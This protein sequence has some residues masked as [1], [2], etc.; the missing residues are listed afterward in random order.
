MVRNALIAAGNSGDLKLMAPIVALLD[1]REP[2]VRSAAIWSLAQVDQDR[3][4]HER[5]DRLP[6]ER[7]D[8]VIAEW[9]LAWPAHAID[10][11]P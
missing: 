3:Y 10:G 2:S 1:D 8:A 7:D 6:L 5:S 9:M 4:R 11:A